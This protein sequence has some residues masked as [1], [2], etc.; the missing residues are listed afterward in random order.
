MRN[1]REKTINFLKKHYGI[2]LVVLVAIICYIGIFGI[3]SLNIFNYNLA[4]RDFYGTGYF[5]LEDINTHYL[6]S[7]FYRLDS[8]HPKIFFSQNLVYPFGTS[9]LNT[10]S[11]P[12]FA[13]T[14]KILYKFFGLSPYA[15]YFGIWILLCLILNGIFGY[16]IAK[17]LNLNNINSIIAS[18]FLIVSP[19]VIPRAFE[20]T[21][22]VAHFFIL[23]AIYLYLINY[24]RFKH[25]AYWTILFMLIFLTQPNFF[26]IVVALFCADYCKRIFI[27]KETNI[28]LFSVFS[29]ILFLLNYLLITQTGL[30]TGRALCGSGYGY[31]SA[32]LNFLINPGIY[33]LF[34]KGMKF[35]TGGQYEGI[36]YLGAG[37]ILLVLFSFFLYPKTKQKPSLLKNIPLISAII[38]LML[39]GFSNKIYLNEHLIFSYP[40]PEFLE[41]IFCIFRTSARGCWI[42]WYMV[43]F[44]GLYIL[45]A[46]IK[47]K[48]LTLLLLLALIIQIADLSPIYKAKYTET[49]YFSSRNF[50]TILKSR[51]WNDEYKKYRGIFT[52]NDTYE[53]LYQYKYFWF[54]A[55]QNNKTVNY[56]YLSR[57]PEEAK[58]LQNEYKQELKNGVV[59]DKTLIYIIS[60]DIYKELAVLAKKDNNVKKIVSK[61]EKI[62]GF[63]IYAD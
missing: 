60:D 22:L 16:K 40:L 50:H 63:Y 36:C 44:F 28:K 20:H 4:L 46:N 19:L 45:N 49:F 38:I 1:F 9:V 25:E 55:I 32:N 21:A 56:G 59:P 53:W 43:F 54:W 33:S 13:L 2:I 6:G 11:L 42:V 10:D 23:A 18:T 48:K 47:A 8:F 12:L 51:K 29:L 15:Q 5:S 27:T 61:T 31:Y 34:F 52:I 17:L 30:L 14:F 39:Y 37:I 35:G 26:P 24:K 3:N 58:E 7:I 62:D 41:N 57:Y